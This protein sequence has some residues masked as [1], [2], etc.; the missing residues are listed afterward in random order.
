M[1]DENL[2]KEKIQSS[3]EEQ[4]LKKPPR[5]MEV[6]YRERSEQLYVIDIN[7]INNHIS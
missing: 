2:L 5:T 4:K 6:L 1:S 3:L 7:T